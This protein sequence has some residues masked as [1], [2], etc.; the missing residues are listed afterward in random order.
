MKDLTAKR[1]TTLNS[2][3]DSR[4]SRRGTRSSLPPTRNGV[5]FDDGA[6]T[7]S[8]QS[9]QLPLQQTE[10]VP[11]NTSAPPA[12]N[13]FHQRSISETQGTDQYEGSRY[14]KQDLPPPPPAHATL[15]G[16]SGHSSLNNSSDAVNERSSSESDSRFQPIKELQPAQAP[17]PVTAPPAF[18]HPPGAQPASKPY[19]HPE[20]RRAKSRMSN[21]TLSQLAGAGGIAVAGAAAA[22]K[23]SPGRRSEEVP[24]A[25]EAPNDATRFDRV[26]PPPP[27]EYQRDPSPLHQAHTQFDGSRQPIE[28]DGKGWRRS[29]TPSPTKSPSIAI[30]G[31]QFEPRTDSLNGPEKVL[32]KPLP[33]VGTERPRTAGSVGDRDRVIARFP[34][35]ASNDDINLG[36]QLTNAS[37]NYDSEPTASPDHASTRQSFERPRAGVMKTVGSVEPGVGVGDAHYSSKTTTNIPDIDFGPTYNY[38][39]SKTASKPA[40]PNIP[41]PT[42]PESG[43]TRSGSA[44]NDRRS[45]AWQPGMGAIGGSSGRALTPE[46]FVHQRAQSRI[47]PGFAHTRSN[48]PPRQSP[49]LANQPRPS[50]G[51]RP[52][53]RGAAATFQ[54]GDYSTRLSAREQEHVAKMTGGPLLNMGPGRLSQGGGLVGAIEARERE[55]QEIKQGISGQMVQQ[56]IN[57]RQSFQ[58]GGQETMYDANGQPITTPP[59]S[60]SQAWAVPSPG[61]RSPGIRGP[62]VG[63]VPSPQEFAARRQ[64]SQFQGNAPD[65]QYRS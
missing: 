64:S 29:R 31:R 37:S 39:S 24:R 4:G 23:M 16:P 12:H 45:I 51:E 33:S 3:R 56:A 48:T 43:H 55:K 10:F 57:H 15:P 60:S 32:R 42:I 46:Q 5:S 19:H 41:E 21:D 14:Q 8:A 13:P 6:S 49:E 30:G 22:W 27:V 53:S 20:L 50:S 47:A 38:A 1:M 28:L 36:R 26:L 44:E 63:Q 7:R 54:T 35:N 34:T 65:G 18:A 17:E 9:H 2:R 52:G 58:Y 61:R 59:Y 40:R 11:R 25:T 62:F